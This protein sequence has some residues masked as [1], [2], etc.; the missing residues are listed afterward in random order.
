MA[1]KNGNKTPN[2]LKNELDLYITHVSSTLKELCDKGLAEC[3]TPEL[4]KGKIFAI[5]TLGDEIIN[6]IS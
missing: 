5:T 1:L 2:E 4:K 6:K 3:L